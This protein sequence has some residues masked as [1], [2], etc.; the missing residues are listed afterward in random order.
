M[1]KACSRLLILFLPLFALA[2]KETELEQAMRRFMA[3]EQMRYGQ[4]GLVVKELQSSKVLIDWNGSIGLAPASTQKIFTAAA[5]LDQLGAGYQYQ[6]GLLTNGMV[7]QGVL[8]GDLII[9]GS[10]DPSFGSWRYGQTKAQQSLDAWADVLKQ[11]GIKE[12]RGQIKANQNGFTQQP[13]PGGWIWDDMGNY[14]GAGTW[15]INWRENQFDLTMVPGDKVGDS[16]KAWRMEPMIPYVQFQNRITTGKPGSGDNGYIYSPP[17]ATHGFAE[18]TIPAG[19]N[20]FT[21]SGAMPNPFQVLQQS[22]E[23]RLQASGIVIKNEVVALSNHP[24]QVLHSYASPTMDSLVYWFMQKSINLYGEALLKTLAQQ[25]S[26]IGN[27]DA[28]VQWIRKYWQERGID[29]NALRMVDGSGLSPLN[30]N[31]AYTQI[32]ALEF[33][34][35]QTWFPAYLQSFPINN[36]MQLKSGTI[37][38]AKAYCGYYTNASGTTYLISFL[39]NNYNGSASA[40]TRKMFTVLDVLK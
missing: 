31:T 29:P 11:S 13:L 30:R 6:T 39:V 10:G 33:A 37:Q 22:L 26:G 4:A 12:V 2:Q 20:S 3:D 8:Y 36:Q 28:G 7:Q 9:Q 19:V 15:G 24:Q 5:A 38:G 32:G 27:T 40:I 25:K 34:S 14:Y 17:Y 16:L 21:I 1:M 23:R 18:G 35:R